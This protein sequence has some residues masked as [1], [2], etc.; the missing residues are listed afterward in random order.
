MTEVQALFLI[1][2]AIYLLQC[3]VWLP[4]DHVAFRRGLRGRWKPVQAGISL[5]ALKLKGVPVNPLPPLPGVVACQPQIIFLSPLGIAALPP[6]AETL[7]QHLAFVGFADIASVR[8]QERLLVINE[9]PFAAFRSTAAAR[10]AASLVGKLANSSPGKRQPAITAE[11]RARFDSK[12]IAD[13][14]AQSTQ[15][16]SMLRFSCNLLFLLLFVLAPLIIWQRTLAASWPYLLA[17]LLCYLAVITWE[18]A[19]AHKSLY[20][21][22][23]DQRFADALSVALSPAGAL[24]SCDP[25]LK[26]LLLDFHPVAVARQLC[27]PAE[28]EALAS[29]TLRELAYPRSGDLESQAEQTRLWWQGAELAALRS[30]LVKSGIDP[31]QWLGAPEREPECRS[32]CPR[33]WSQFV[34]QEGT[35]TECGDI[36]L[37]P[38]AEDA[39][40]QPLSAG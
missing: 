6:N 5:E 2:G 12:A 4:R 19:R 8:T 30:F 26:D 23:R 37:R 7:Q 34:I 39:L 3:V 27:A 14:L 15:A 20:P 29:R 35:C 13:R 38:F 22:R 36:T 32:F 40:S 9:G 33:C 10:D 18:F 16:T 28:F 25:L 31:A 17:V 21:E 24:R 11:V 1:L